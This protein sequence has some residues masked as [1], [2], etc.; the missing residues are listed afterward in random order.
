MSAEIGSV[1]QSPENSVAQ[2]PGD[3]YSNLKRKKEVPPLRVRENLLLRVIRF[4][5]KILPE[6]WFI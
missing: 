5:F 4:S 6:T 2:V 1:H 3:S